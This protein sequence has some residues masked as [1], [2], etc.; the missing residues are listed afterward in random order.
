[1]QRRARQFL[2]LLVT[3]G[4]VGACNDAPNHPSE[5]D[6]EGTYAATAFTVTTADTTFDQLAEGVSLTI[7]LHADG[8]TT[9]TLFVP[10]VA[11]DLAGTWDTAAAVVRFQQTAPNFLNQMPFEIGADVLRGELAVPLGTIRVTLAK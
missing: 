1:M 8:S 3:T 4:T 9:G 5:A 6:L 11:V 7:T 10:N 2:F